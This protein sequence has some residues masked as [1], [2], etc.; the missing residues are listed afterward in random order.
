MSFRFRDRQPRQPYAPR[1]GLGPEWVSASGRL[2][3]HTLSEGD[4]MPTS[5]RTERSSRRVRAMAG[6]RVVADTIRPLLVWEVPY[7]PTYYFPADDVAED[8]LVE[9]GT[10]VRTRLRT[11]ANL[12][13]LKV[14]GAVRRNA[15]YRHAEG[16]EAELHDHYALV[17]DAVDHWFEED[18]EVYVHPRDPYTRVDVLPSSR[19]VRIE[20]DGETV[21]DSR[22]PSMLFETGLPPRYYLPKT[23]VRFD[24]LSPSDTTS[25]CPYKG[26]A[27][28]WD[29]TV[30]GVTHPD[31]LWGYDFPARE[32]EK[33]AGL[34][35]FY[36]EKVDV[37][38]DGQLQERPRTKFG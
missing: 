27:R 17:W 14:D 38:L 33:I 10:T 3:L 35:C 6:G 8:V 18:E 32:S 9:N 7:F 26:T 28:Y 29:L 25:R 37:Y 30:N 22:R 4:T 16:T 5:I 15:A 13:D 1:V 20:V 21:A 36:N 19:H 31:I 24:L 12:Y 2:R 23:D 11:E 34:V